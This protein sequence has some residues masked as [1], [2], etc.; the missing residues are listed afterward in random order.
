MWLQRE[1][2]HGT[3][4]LEDTKVLSVELIVGQSLGS[5]SYIPNLV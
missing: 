2:I 1:V 4:S 5:Q 3:V